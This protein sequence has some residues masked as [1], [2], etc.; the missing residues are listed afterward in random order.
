MNNEGKEKKERLYFKEGKSQ[1][2]KR[3]QGDFKN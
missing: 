2:E 3:N 1:D